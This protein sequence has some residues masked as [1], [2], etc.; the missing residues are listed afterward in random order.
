VGGSFTIAGGLGR[1]HI[2]MLDGT[3]GVPTAWNPSL[4]G[5]VYSLALGSGRVYAGGAFT[6]LGGTARNNAAAFDVT[7][8][9]PT[10]WD[11]NANNDVTALRI[12]VGKT[13]VGGPFTAVGCDGMACRSGRHL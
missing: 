11:A 1:S 2:A 8:G 6:S 3:S 4:N 5:D 12:A 9:K 10:A 13:Y 7:T